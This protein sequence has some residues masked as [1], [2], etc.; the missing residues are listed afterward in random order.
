MSG[1]CAGKHVVIP[2]K[3]NIERAVKDNYGFIALGTDMLHLQAG[4]QK[5]IEIFDGAL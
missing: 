5:C 1:I 2:T 4:S 3:Q